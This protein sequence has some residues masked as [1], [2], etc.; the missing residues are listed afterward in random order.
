MHLEI[1]IHNSNPLLKH[2]M[3]W[4]QPNYADQATKPENEEP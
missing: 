1:Q 2:T 4:V 3:Y